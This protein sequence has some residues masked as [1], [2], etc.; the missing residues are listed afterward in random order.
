VSVLAYFLPF[1]EDFYPQSYEFSNVPS[2][3]NMIW[4]NMSLNTKL[5]IG[6]KLILI[7]FTG[8]LTPTALSGFLVAVA[9]RCEC[10]GV[11]IQVEP[12][13]TDFPVEILIGH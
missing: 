10:S 12:N 13:L 8:S 9:P 5:P 6:S 7:G 1:N 3:D 2:E 11:W 4:A